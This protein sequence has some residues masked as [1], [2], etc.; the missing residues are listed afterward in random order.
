MGGLS[1]NVQAGF[2]LSGDVPV[3]LRKFM[4]M[5]AAASSSA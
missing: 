1:A 3:R 2:A 4:L 5:A